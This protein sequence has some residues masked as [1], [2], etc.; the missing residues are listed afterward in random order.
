MNCLNRAKGLKW[1][2][3]K[4]ITKAVDY[5]LLVVSSSAFRENEMIPEKYTCDGVNISPPLDIKDIPE[6]TKCLAIIMDDPDAP[7][8]T[9]VHWVVWNIPVTHHVKENKVHGIA[10]TNDFG[11]LVYC[12]PCPPKGIHRNFFKVYALDANLDLPPGS[13]KYELEKS[14]SEHIIAF[15]ELFGWY[16]RKN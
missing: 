3:M 6:E 2:H 8:N 9:W 12:G 13:S 14:M 10:G 15:G 4:H 1:I 5:K 11:K 16:Q 7:V